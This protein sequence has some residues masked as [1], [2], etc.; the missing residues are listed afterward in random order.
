MTYVKSARGRLGK[1]AGCFNILAKQKEEAIQ[2]SRLS[3]EVHRGLQEV[4]EVRSP[5]L[6][7]INIPRINKPVEK[8]GV[9]KRANGNRLERLMK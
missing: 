9:W 8:V 1:T 5:A 6:K 4:D 2:S 3:P 7:E